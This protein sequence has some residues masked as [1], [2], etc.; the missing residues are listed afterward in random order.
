EP[1]ALPFAA[2]AQAGGA[3]LRLGIEGAPALA[4]ALLAIARCACAD[5]LPL[6]I[7]CGASADARVLTPFWPALLHPDWNAPLA[8]FQAR[9]AQVL[10]RADASGGVLA[11]LHA[12]EPEL[13]GAS[14]AQALPVRL[15]RPGHG[16]MED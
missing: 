14:P 11:D 10:A 1:F 4:A 7:G 3:D 9:L 15:L 8:D 2:P 16:D 12:R 13:H 6:A 5:A